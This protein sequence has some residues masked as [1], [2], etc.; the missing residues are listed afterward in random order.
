M[1][2]PMGMHTG[3][4]VDHLCD[5]SVKVIR[6]VRKGAIYSGCTMSV[7]SCTLVIVC[8]VVAVYVEGYH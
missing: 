7:F 2:K 6:P 5:V 1:L 3:L 4:F 8:M